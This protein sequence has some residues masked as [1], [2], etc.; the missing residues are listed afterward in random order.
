MHT[1]K[2]SQHLFTTSSFRT[3]Q[4]L[5]DHERGVKAFGEMQIEGLFALL[6]EGGSDEMGPHVLWGTVEADGVCSL[7]QVVTWTTR[8]SPWFLVS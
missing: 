2:T 4:A 3:L 1:P 7:R 5:L 6:G 8:L